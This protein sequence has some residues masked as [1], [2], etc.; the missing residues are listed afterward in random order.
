MSTP[1]V[2]W[3]H[4]FFVSKVSGSLQWSGHSTFFVSS[5]TGT[6]SPVARGPRSP[7]SD[8]PEFSPA[9]GGL[10]KRDSVAESTGS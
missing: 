6:P 1:G 4:V 5:G 8:R 2:K 9:R 10:F 7:D 3:A